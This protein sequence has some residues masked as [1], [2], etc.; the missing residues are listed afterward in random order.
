[1]NI[2]IYFDNAATT[3]PKPNIVKNNI[4]SIFNKF[5]G[6]PGRSGH[7]M[8]METSLM[9][10]S[11]REAL[12]K[13][14]GA[15]NTEDVVFCLN[16]TMA[17][18]MAIKGI[19]SP[20]DHVIISSYEHNAVLRPIH[21]L[22]QLGLITYD[23]ADIYEN[24]IDKT[25]SSYKR[26][27]KRNTKL[28]I[29][30]HGSN[31]FGN[32]LPVKEISDI[33][34]K[35][36]AMFLIDA[37]QTAGVIPINIQELNIDFFCAPGHKSLY[38]LSGIGILITNHGKRLS[39]VIEGGTGSLSQSFSQPDFMP[40]RLESGTVNTAGILGLY[41]GLKFINQRG[42]T[43][44]YSH[45]MKIIQYIYNRLS[46][47]KNIILYTDYP[48]LNT[49]L[50]VLS[51]NVKDMSCDEVIKNLNEKGF[52]LRG[53]LHCAPLAHQSKGTLEIGTV[54]ISVGAFNTVAQANKLCNAISSL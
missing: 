21:K 24:D 36:G 1:M 17:I 27:I 41:N 33:A 2:L 38:G 51:F 39:T 44:I 10:Y 50:P 37:A 35:N 49:Y 8:A 6:N 7:N 15:H 42:I 19:L 9:I 12:A 31:V 47:N 30:I 28:I 11:C 29:A 32:I 20:G 54:R 40:D 46:N 25:L 53:G 5:G 34:H 26:L 48:S 3:F 52:A 13:L 16:C 23:I 4:K 18:N 43:N 14:F 45:E 22:K